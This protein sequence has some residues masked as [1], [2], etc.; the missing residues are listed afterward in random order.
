VPAQMNPGRSSRGRRWFDRNVESKPFSEQNPGL[1]PPESRAFC[2][3]QG[4]EVEAQ[5]GT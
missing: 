3:V 5:R 2:E 4:G 1:L